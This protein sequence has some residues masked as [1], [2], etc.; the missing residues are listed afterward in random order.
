M[1]IDNTQTEGDRIWQNVARPAYLKHERN[2]AYALDA[3]QPA[4]PCR[5]P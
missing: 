1:T 5:N 3:R 2:R 4:W